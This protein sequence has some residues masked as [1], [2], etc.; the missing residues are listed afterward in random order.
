MVTT[1]PPLPLTTLCA[2][3]REMRCENAQPDHREHDG[4]RCSCCSPRQLGDRS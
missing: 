2:A 1:T 4:C 3:C